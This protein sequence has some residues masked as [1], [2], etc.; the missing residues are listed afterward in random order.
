MSAR[1]EY[2]LEAYI[3]RSTEGPCFVCAFLGG[4]P[5]YR[6][7][8]VYEN[9]ETVAFPTR[10]PTLLGYTVVCPRRHLESWVADMEVDE[11]LRFQGTVH[12]VAR[13]L[14]ATVPTERMY[15]MSLGSRQGNAQRFRHRLGDYDKAE[16]EAVFVPAV[17][18]IEL[19]E[20]QGWV[21]L[22]RTAQEACEISA[23]QQ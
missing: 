8:L 17:K 13:A 6:H 18:E 14:E 19:S 21:G 3:K 1:P 9:Q 20:T 2:D 4:H 5:D 7:H 10:Y 12:R 23:G 11:F 22:R 16:R 15:S